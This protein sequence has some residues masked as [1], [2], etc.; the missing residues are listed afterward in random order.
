[1]HIFVFSLSYPHLNFHCN[2]VHFMDPCYC[3]HDCSRC[4][5]YLATISSDDTLRLRAQKFYAEMGY[6]LSLKDISCMGGRSDHVFCLCLSCP[7]MRCCREKGISS[8]T[9]CAS[10]CEMFKNYQIRYVNNSN[11]M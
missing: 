6:D 11:Q 5:T 10:P 3:G 9:L 8:C 7:F 4:V 2:G 1:M